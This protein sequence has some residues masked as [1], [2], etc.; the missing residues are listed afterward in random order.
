MSADIDLQQLY[1][2]AMRHHPF[3]FALYH[4]CDKTVLKPGSVGYFNVRGDW[5]PITH[6]LS[7]DEPFTMADDELQ[8]GD[9]QLPEWGPKCSERVTEHRLQ[10]Q[11]K[12]FSRSDCMLI[13]ALCRVY[14]LMSTS[15]A[16]I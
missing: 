2:N 15:F 5:N 1:A 14:L 3:G 4:P 10:G 6:I 11:A 9:A 7:S 16:N 12:M 8:L 13:I